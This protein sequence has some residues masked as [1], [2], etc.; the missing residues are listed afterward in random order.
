MMNAYSLGLNAWKTRKVLAH[1]MLW[2]GSIDKTMRISGESKT[3]K[4]AAHTLHKKRMSAHLTFLLGLHP[5]HRLHQKQGN[6]A[7][8]HQGWSMVLAHQLYSGSAKRVFWK[9]RLGCSWQQSGES[10]RQ[11]CFSTDSKGTAIQMPGDA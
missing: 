9:I 11:S 6:Q 1:T 2:N 5:P 8:V 7:S 3:F 4:Q 10:L